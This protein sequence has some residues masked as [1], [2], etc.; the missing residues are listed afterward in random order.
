MSMRKLLTVLIVAI[1][2]LCGC[3][4]QNNQKGLATEAVRA[5]NQYMKEGKIDQAYSMFSQRIKKKLTLEDFRTSVQPKK[6]KEQ[7]YKEMIKTFELT[8]ERE[9]V[10]GNNAVVYGTIKMESGVSYF[11]TKCVLENNVWKVDSEVLEDQSPDNKDFYRDVDLHKTF[12]QYCDFLLK[13]YSEKMYE[14]SSS[15]IKSMYSPEIFKEQTTATGSDN[16]PE[17]EGFSIKAEYAYSDDNG[18]GIC[19]M[20]M[21]NMSYGTK[22][23]QS[24]ILFKLPWVLENGVWKANFARIDDTYKMKKVSQ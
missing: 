11:R 21:G 20:T 15:S 13:G 22:E 14:M 5:I 3:K 24:G 12:S 10:T 7:Q 1:S 2:I 17:K 16:T 6:D 23:L 18:N 4:G 8:F 19:F 9:E